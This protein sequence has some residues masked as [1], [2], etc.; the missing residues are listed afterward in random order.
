MRV[1]CLSVQGGVLVLEL[2][3]MERLA[4]FRGD[5]CVRLETVQAVTV[6]EN[7]WGA[8]RGVRAPGTG[9]P[10]VIAYGVRLATG[11]AP[12][13]AAL[14]GRGPALR[15]D[16]KPGAPFGRLLVTVPEPDATAAAIRRCLTP[17][18]DV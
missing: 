1:A 6:D 7:P 8:L 18:R 13:F 4:A 11:G 14:H 16:L 17:A 3:S 12:D 15:I 2:S 9:L 10:G 5:V